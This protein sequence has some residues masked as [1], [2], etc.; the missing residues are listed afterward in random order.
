RA[1]QRMAPAEPLDGHHARPVD[2]RHR[3]QARVHRS[4]VDQQRA[5]AALTLSAA[6]LRSGESALLAQ[7]VEQALHRMYVQTGPPAVERQ[8]NSHRSTLNLWVPGCFW[9]PR[10][11]ISDSLQTSHFTLHFRLET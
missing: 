8:D 5:G 2:V 6:F 9:L 11:S 7:H 4:V 10:F 3:Y 1:L